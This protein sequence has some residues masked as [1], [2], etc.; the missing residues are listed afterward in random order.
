MIMAADSEIQKYYAGK[1]VF[2]TG[3][4]GF[5]GKVLIEKLLRCCP[6]INKIYILVRHKKNKSPQ[7][8]VNE[9]LGCEV[10]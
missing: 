3:A 4:T 10:H 1:C 2:I 6:E 7:Q 5:L 9:I 8:R